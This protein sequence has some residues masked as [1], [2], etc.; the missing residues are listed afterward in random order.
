MSS[1]TSRPTPPARMDPGLQRWFLPL[2]LLVLAL[3]V[4]LARFV[5]PYADDWSYAVAGM[6]TELLPRLWDEYH[7]W[8]GRYFS[9][10]LVLRGPLVLG[11]EHGLTIY[12]FVPVALILLTWAGA[13][14]LIRTITAGIVD[15]SRALFGALVFV[16]VFLNVM[17]DISEGIYWYTG[18][19]TYQ[20][21]NAL[22]LFL[23]AGWAV[24]LRSPGKPGTSL[25]IAMALLVVVIVGCNE[26]HM[27]FMVL[28]H[29]A[30]LA[31]RYR[32]SGRVHPALAAMLVLSLACAAIVYFAPGNEM[33]GG[34]FPQRQ[35][36]FHSLW[37]GALQTGRFLLAWIFSPALLI[38]SILYIPVGR[39]LAQRVPLFDNA[40]G[41]KPLMAAAVVVVPVYLAMA[42]PYWSTGILGQHRTV[43]AT[44]FFFLPTWF[45]MLTVIDV[46]VLRKGGFRSLPFERNRTMLSILLALALLF[47]RNT[48]AIVSDFWNQRLSS[49]DAQLEW[50]YR[51]LV[52]TQ[53]TGT[54]RVTLPAL[55]DP[56]RS[57][58][59]LEATADPTHWI[60]RSMAYYFGAD[61]LDIA[62]V[63]DP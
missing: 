25:P 57:L 19:V 12:R 29:A 42:L 23:V 3:Y 17:P 16:L 51:I 20:L 34:Q 55:K 56:P 13:Y 61:T 38:M 48:G 9:N 2:L 1:L 31:F 47:T 36:F 40:F 6:R 50:R 7:L 58:H 8:N 22:S 10:V 45:M 43:N 46:N 35:H 15:R 53:R 54:D 63:P 5:H 44:L 60:N 4:L 28:L 62:V 21:A 30:L 49:Y 14:V 27:V 33:R 24:V 39:W 37:W 18:S 59:I 11:L 41:L 32:S 52:W 26:L